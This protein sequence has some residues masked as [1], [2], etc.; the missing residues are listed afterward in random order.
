MNV[1]ID[2][3]VDADV[4]AKDGE[5]RSA[6]HFACG[7]GEMKCAEML[8]DAKADVNAVDKNK[9]TPL[10]YAAYSGLRANAGILVNAG[11]DPALKNSKGQTAAEEAKAQGKQDVINRIQ[12]GVDPSDE[13]D[14]E[15]AAAGSA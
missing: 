10:H 7:Y 8:C 15:P 14:E 2:F 6:L 1:D 3:D 11:A 12:K 5:G 9:N 4:N 13:L